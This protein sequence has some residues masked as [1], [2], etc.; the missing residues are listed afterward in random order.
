MGME[1][2]L[3]LLADGYAGAKFYIKYP[4]LEQ[5]FLVI[6]KRYRLVIEEVKDGI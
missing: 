1:L 4:L 2:I 5:R 3:P 6:G